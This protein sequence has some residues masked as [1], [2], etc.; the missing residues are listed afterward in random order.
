VTKQQ[1]ATDVVIIGGGLSGL[2]AA[3]ILKRAGFAVVVLEANNRLGGRLLSH[4]FPTGERGDVGGQWFGPGQNR[5]LALAAEFGL[6]VHE[7][8]TRGRTAYEFEKRRGSYAGALPWLNPLVLL[9]TLIGFWRLSRAAARLRG[10]PIWGTELAESLDQQSVQD[11]I[12]ANVWTAAAR[13]FMRLSLEGI[14][15]CSADRASLLLLLHGIATS[16]SLEHMFGVKG[17]AQERQFTNGT[18]QLIEGIANELVE[19]IHLNHAVTRIE[20]HARGATIVGDTFALDT[21]YVVLAAPGP[22]VKAIEFR[23]PLETQR[24]ALLTH[25]EMGAVVKC[26]VQYSRPFWRDKGLSGALWSDRGPA[27]FT[28]DTSSPDSDR[29][30]LSVIATAS[31]AEY[32]SGLAPEARRHAVL[33][34]LVRHFGR[35]ARDC[36][37]YADKVWTEEPWARGGYA[38]HLPPGRFA[39]GMAPYQRPEGVLHWASTETANEWPGY[40]EGAIEAGERAASELIRLR[41]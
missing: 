17:G 30:H 31:R 38:A 8:A 4:T 25:F 2:I 19:S 23:P 34:S 36:L 24:Q 10:R 12:A 29:G 41:G 32:L 15:C 9:A 13:K 1:G 33:D 40:M 3:R 7:T 18:Q 27:D 6:P 37:D 39:H 28:Y 21:K 14:L 16:G 20:H 11:W 5:I 35:E 22:L 26:V